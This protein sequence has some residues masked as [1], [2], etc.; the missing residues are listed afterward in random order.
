MTEQAVVEQTEEQAKPVTEADDAQDLD[1]IL[2]QYATD[3]QET[4]EDTPKKDE[5]A[6]LRERI[7][8]REREELQAKIQEDIGKSVSRIKDNL[9]DSSINV[10]DRIVRGLLNE[11]AQADPRIL[12]AFNDRYN[13]PQNWERVE[14]QLAKDLISELSIDPSAT[15][16]V[17]AVRN[18]VRGSQPVTDDPPDFSKMSDRDFEKMKRELAG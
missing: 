1:A 10:S 17:N 15:A 13:N 18:H 2:S 12:R 16:S 11:A 3:E 8:R 5:V 9:K 14:S 7:E 4:T 6:E